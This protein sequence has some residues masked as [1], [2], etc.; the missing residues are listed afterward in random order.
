MF[1]RTEN[2]ASLYLILRA[3]GGREHHVLKK[4]FLKRDF[5]MATQKNIYIYTYMCMYV[6]MYVYIYICIYMNEDPIED[7]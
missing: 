3:C 6:C 2:L 1:F 7:S 4:I 5:L